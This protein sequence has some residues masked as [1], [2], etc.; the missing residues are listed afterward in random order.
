V[1]NTQKPGAK[2]P[3]ARKPEA[4][5]Y[6]MPML[7]LPGSMN[8]PKRALGRKTGQVPQMKKLR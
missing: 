6:K 7:K 8:M 1:A 5:A 3:R 4:G 2:Y